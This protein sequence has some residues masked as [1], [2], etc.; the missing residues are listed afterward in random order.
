MSD[1]LKMDIFFVATTVAVVVVGAC[2][3]YAFWRLER[4]LKHIE[5][6]SQ[7]VAL[8]S[9]T[10]RADLA[11]VRSDIRRGKGRLAAMFDF[12]QKSGKRAKKDV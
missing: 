11:E 10:I 5:H 1:F 9:D 12:L 2:A 6:I 8:E 7:Q 4:V 3:S